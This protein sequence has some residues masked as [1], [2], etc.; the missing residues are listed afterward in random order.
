MA[1]DLKT[2]LRSANETAP[3]IA[4]IGQQT[5][6]DLKGVVNHASWRG[7]ILIEVFLAG[8]IPVRLAYR[9]IGRKSPGRRL[10]EKLL[11]PAAF[12]GGFFLK[13]GG[14]ARPGGGP[15]LPKRGRAR[16][17]P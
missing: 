17:R 16:R 8:L 2:L 9:A 15:G 13:W 5:S 1:R 4:K 10:P 14:P 7:H 3:A 11:R 6:K 12:S